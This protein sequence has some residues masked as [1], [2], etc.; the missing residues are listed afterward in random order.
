[1]QIEFVFSCRECGADSHI[2][3]DTAQELGD[4][5]VLKCSSWK[6]HHV[7]GELR[8]GYVYREEHGPSSEREEGPEFIPDICRCNIAGSDC[9]L[10]PAD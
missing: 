8:P 2:L 9:K 4:A 6:C 7:S 10:H 1:M 5:V 3:W